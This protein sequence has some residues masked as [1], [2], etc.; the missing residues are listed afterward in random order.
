[1]FYVKLYYPQKSRT[2]NRKTDFRNVPYKNIVSPSIPVNLE[3]IT[4]TLRSLTEMC[5]AFVRRLIP[6]GSSRWAYQMLCLIAEVK[7]NKKLKYG[8]I[9]GARFSAYF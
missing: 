2:T 7:K 9:N 8:N 1:M 6:T 3:K 4:I 5:D